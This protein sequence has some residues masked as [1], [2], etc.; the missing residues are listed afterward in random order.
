MHRKPHLGESCHH[1]TFGKAMQT[2]R[3]LAG[4]R[5]R[6]ALERRPS[7]FDPGARGMGGQWTTGM[8]VARIMKAGHKAGKNGS[9]N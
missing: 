8:A 4:V 5:R 9:K 7:W 3:A 1:Q 6:G 2:A